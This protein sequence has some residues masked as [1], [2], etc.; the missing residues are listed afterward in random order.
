METSDHLLVDCVFTQEVWK[1]VLHGLSV[2]TPSQIS[3]VT[4]YTSWVDQNHEKKS[5]NIGWKEIWQDIPK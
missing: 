2:P 4:L 5:K 3:V 1:M